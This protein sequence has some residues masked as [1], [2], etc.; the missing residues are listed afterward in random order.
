ML[1]PGKVSVVN[2]SGKKVAVSYQW[3]AGMSPAKKQEMPAKQW[4][5]SA[6]PG[7]QGVQVWRSQAGKISHWESLAQN[8]GQQESGW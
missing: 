6:A 8:G 7:R 2:T 3:R 5:P 4:P 1:S